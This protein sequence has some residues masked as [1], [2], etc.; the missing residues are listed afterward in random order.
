MDILATPLKSLNL[1]SLVKINN[2]NLRIKANK[3]LCFADKIKWSKI[4]ANP[5]KQNSE[6]YYN[7]NP[8]ECGM[9]D[10]LCDAMAFKF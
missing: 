1:T 7:K 5:K 10:F 9:C 3:N 2:G 4:L 6:V 8:E